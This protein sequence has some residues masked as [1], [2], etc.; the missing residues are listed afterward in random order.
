M[1]AMEAAVPRRPHTDDWDFPAWKESVLRVDFAFSLHF[2]GSTPIAALK[3]TSC[4][5]L[6]LP[7]QAL[8]MAS[9]SGLELPLR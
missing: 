4:L 1:A 6:P 8:V 7:E 9:P 5:P 3:H 2:E